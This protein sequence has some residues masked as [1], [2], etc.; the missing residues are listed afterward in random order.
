[1]KTL[2]GI[3]TL[4][5]IAAFGAGIATLSVDADAWNKKTVITISDPMQ[6]PGATLTPGKYVFKLMDSSSNRHIVQVF[7]EDETKVIN[8]IL[9]IPNQRLQ[10]TGKSEFGFWEVP[11]G[12]TSALRSWFYPGD[13]SG[14]E[15]AYPK[16]EATKLSAVVKEEVPSISEEEYA[17]ATKVTPAPEPAAAE[18]K[19]PE[20][21]PVTPAPEV[22]V[23]ETPKPVETPAVA[24]PAPTPAP[25][26]TPAPAPRTSEPV[27]AADDTLPATA[28]PLPVLGLLGFLSV[29]VGA[30]LRSLR[31][32]LS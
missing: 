22:A 16:Q 19:T 1:M 14:H 8:T 2:K 25:T 6:I 23:A 3:I 15:F 28:S 26:P 17:Q 12:S 11:A 9:A 5:C 27:A 30:L 32:W 31:G 24:E 20:P 18:V 21:Q 10:P 13:N 4:C 29:G 7:N